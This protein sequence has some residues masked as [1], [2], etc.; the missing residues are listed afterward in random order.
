MERLP[1]WKQVFRIRQRIIDPS[2]LF[3]DWVN[4]ESLPSLSDC[5]KR[6]GLSE[7]VTHNAVEDAWDVIERDY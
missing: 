6:A 4:D 5:K 7:I 2:I 3:T 1:R